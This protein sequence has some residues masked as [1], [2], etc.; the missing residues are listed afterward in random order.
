MATAASV[1]AKI[2]NLIRTANA[3][4]GNADT[5]LATAIGSLIAG[6]GTG[7][8]SGG[9]PAGIS[10]LASGTFTPTDDV[11]SQ[12]SVQHGLGVTP[13]FF[14]LFAE[15]SSLNKDDFQYYISAEFGL[16][17]PFALTTD[18]S[19]SGFRIYRY[20]NANIFTQSVSNAEG[21]VNVDVIVVYASSTYA[22]KAGVTYRWVAGVIDGL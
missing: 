3:T 15:G 6:Y 11:T 13:N 1:T 10:A 17:Q 12:Y 16:L 19:Y 2:Q 14:F 9:L 21:F 22:L 20:A 8:G 4:T 5:D 7:G 18:T